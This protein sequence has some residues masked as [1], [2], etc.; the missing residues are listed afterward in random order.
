MPRPG[1]DA[2]YGYLLKCERIYDVVGMLH[3]DK[4][5]SDWGTLCR[6]A[7]AVIAPSQ[8]LV[9]IMRLLQAR[10]LNV[11]IVTVA[12]DSEE[13][14]TDYEHTHIAGTTETRA[15]ATAIVNALGPMACTTM[16]GTV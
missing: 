5:Q 3:I 15:L 11:P 9:E 8:R 7:D 2:Q 14:L 4:D 1:A 12:G 6:G 16:G 10:E 13:F